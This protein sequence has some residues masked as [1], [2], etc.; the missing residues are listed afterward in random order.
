MQLFCH[1]LAVLMYVQCKRSVAFT[2]SKIN[3]SEPD[4]D[5]YF[6]KAYPLPPLY[7]RR[8]QF[9]ADIT[10]DPCI[11]PWHLYVLQFMH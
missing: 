11:L 4:T 2:E 9:W 3:A 10:A 5:I 8:G 1:F 7:V 6:K